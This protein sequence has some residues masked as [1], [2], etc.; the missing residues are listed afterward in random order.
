VILVT[1]GAGYVGSVVVEELLKQ[2]Y[3]VVVVDNLQQG[4][5]AAVLPGARFVKADYG[6]VPAIDR[7]FA[8]FPVDS[9]MHLAADSIIS[10][11]VSDPQQC[12]HNNVANGLNLLNTMLRHNV[13]KIIFSSSAAVYGQPTDLPI[14]EN[15]ELKP[16][17]PYGETKLMFEKILQW[18]GK[19]YR[20]GHISLRY[21][22]AAGASEKLGEDHAPETHLIPNVLK[23]ALVPSSP[24]HIFGDNYVTRDGSCIR[25]Y[26]H[27]IDIARAHIRALERIS[28]LSGRAYNLGSSSGYSV[29]Q[30][31]NMAQKIC[32]VEIPRVI[33]PRRDGDPTI[34]TASSKRAK[35]DL[36]WEPQYPGLD[37]IIGS[38]WKWAQSHPQG[39]SGNIDTP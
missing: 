38:A 28:D 7:L 11:S 35:L 20:L 23:A 5:R 21:F 27:V 10:A 25:D 22:N 30:V 2:N 16:V 33:S 15:Q 39:Y 17:N 6:N 14:L 9:V 8:R 37:T 34:L 19:A 36:D 12:F 3:P 29:F 32:G 18:Y 1:G 4:H 13:K 26:V 31:V 24:L